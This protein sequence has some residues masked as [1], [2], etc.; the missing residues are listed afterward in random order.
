MAD[1][2]RLGM[3][4]TEQRKQRAAIQAE[5][6]IKGDGYGAEQRCRTTRG[7]E[8][9]DVRRTSRTADVA[10]LEADDGRLSLSVE[11]SQIRPV[12]RRR[13]KAAQASNEG[14]SES[15]NAGCRRCQYGTVLV[16]VSAASAE[17][18]SHQ[19]H[20]TA[21]SLQA[22]LDYSIPSPSAGATKGSPGCVWQLLRSAKR[23]EDRRILSKGTARCWSWRPVRREIWKQ[24]SAPD[25]SR[26]YLSHKPLG[27]ATSQCQAQCNDVAE[28]ER[29]LDQ[30]VGRRTRTDRNGGQLASV[31]VRAR[32]R[33][34]CS[35]AVVV[36]W[37]LK[38]R[39]KTQELEPIV[40]SLSLEFSREFIEVGCLE[41]Q[42]ERACPSKANDHRHM[43]CR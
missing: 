15:G 28:T 24:A 33:T 8:P 7:K 34:L 38:G 18:P 22:V 3:N 41:A 39:A 4:S 42:G 29:K 13:A 27:T 25:V 16:R 11:S 5:P 17:V 35:R 12:M 37:S 2:D 43:I 40:S 36:L 14:C 26:V 10:K 21:E 31:N 30:T 19:L 20:Q 32:R 9:E 6:A 23:A 1:N